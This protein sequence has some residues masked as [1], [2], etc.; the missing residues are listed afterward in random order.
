MCGR[1]NKCMVCCRKPRSF[2]YNKLV[3]LVYIPALSLCALLHRMAFAAASNI[4]CEVVEHAC[5]ALASSSAGA[6][7]CRL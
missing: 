3:P 2:D 1:L 6:F 4:A 7:L 5:T